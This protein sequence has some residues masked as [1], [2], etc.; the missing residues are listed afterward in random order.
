MENCC[1]LVFYIDTEIFDR[2]I[3]AKTVGKSRAFDREDRIRPF[4]L[5]ILASDQI[6][7]QGFTGIVKMA[8][9]SYVLQTA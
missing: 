2:R 4:L 7:A 9:V 5:L 8:I 6:N 1:R 3:S